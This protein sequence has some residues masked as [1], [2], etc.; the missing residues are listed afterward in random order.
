[1][2]S[3]S[4]TTIIN[5]HN[6]VYHLYADDKQ[7][8]KSVTLDKTANMLSDLSGCILSFKDLMISNNLKMNDK[9]KIM[10][11]GTNTKLNSSNVSNIIVED[12]ELLLSS[13]VKDLGTCI[14]IDNTVYG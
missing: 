4:V 12:I 10:L 2:Y 8:Y 11:V 7:L 1:M 3:Q 13:H 5:S 6:S 14:I 9:T